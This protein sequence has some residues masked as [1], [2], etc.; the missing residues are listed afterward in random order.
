MIDAHV[1]LRDWNQKEK[2]SLEHGFKVAKKAHFT[3]LFDMPNTDPPLTT[4]ENILKRIKEAQKLD[5]SIFYGVYAGVT[6][7]ENQLSEVVELAKTN[8][9][10][11]GLKMYAGHSTGN[12][13]LTSS[14]VQQ[15]VYQLLVK[16]DYRGVLAVHCEKEELMDNSLYDK[17]KPET[18]LL[19]RPAIAEIESVREQIEFVKNCGF[20]GTL[21]IAHISTKGAI[22]LVTKAKKEGI[23][24]TSGATSHHALLT[25]SL[26][27]T[28]DNLLKM[29][30]PLRSEEDRLAVFN[31][32]LSGQ[33]D[34]IESD[35][36]P[37]TLLDKQNGASGIPGFVGTLLLIKRLR[38]A[39]VGEKQLKNLLG[40]N[41][42]KV[43]NLNL[44]ITIPSN[45]MIEK[46]LPNLRGEYFYD[47]F[48]SLS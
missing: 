32:L 9:N 36:A 13:G 21:H 11:I 47:P 43:F 1:H 33:V 18:H 10:V 15:K 14:L 44:K 20:K 34:W 25:S 16:N 46:A 8:E 38:E 41:Q 23:K 3:A 37:H 5:D 29:N 28:K 12:R 45:E 2:E 26:A 17:A 31:S 40:N 6:S 4:K 24:V 35:H 42:N 39:N 48:I 7:D 27:F 19:A 30:P 22:D